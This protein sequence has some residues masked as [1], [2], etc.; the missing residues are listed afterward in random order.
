MESIV[1]LTPNT[2]GFGKDWNLKVTTNETSKTFYLGQDI[3]FCHRV[4][5]IEPEQVM[6]EICEQNLKT[7]SALEKL[8]NFIIET[9]GLSE[10]EIDQLKPWELCCQ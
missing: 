5:G 1:V 10:D 3:K 9:L 6:N 8:G 7:K 4:L 2:Y